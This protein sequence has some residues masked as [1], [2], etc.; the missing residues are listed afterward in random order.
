MPRHFQIKS[1]LCSASS[2]GV[3]MQVHVPV[4]MAPGD[5]ALC[6]ECLQLF[7]WVI[8]QKRTL[9]TRENALPCCISGLLQNIPGAWLQVCKMVLCPLSFL[10]KKD[11]FWQ[12][13]AEPVGVL[14]ILQWRCCGRHHK[15][16]IL[17]ALRASCASE[18]LW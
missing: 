9:G 7:I 8:T 14:R 6:R 18:L 15:V 10:P 5:E 4:H 16:G 12:V 2:A 11:E 13:L 3:R 17:M 1:P